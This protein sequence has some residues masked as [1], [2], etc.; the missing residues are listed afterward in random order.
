M[1]AF[2][3]MSR[4]SR[5][6]NADMAGKEVIAMIR[7]GFCDGCGRLTTLGHV[8]CAGQDLCAQCASV[9][10]GR[11]VEEVQAYLEREL[12]NQQITITEEFEEV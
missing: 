6:P 2:G 1:L 8:S 11:E 4:N 5:S 3:G 10:I 9:L 12:A 7:E